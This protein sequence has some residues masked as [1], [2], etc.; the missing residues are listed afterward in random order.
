MAFISR[1]APFL[2]LFSLLSCMAVTVACVTTPANSCQRNCCINESAAAIG[3]ALTDAEVDPYLQES[4]SIAEVN[5]NATT[6]ISLNGSEMTIKTHDVMID[7]PGSLVHVHVDVQNCTVVGIWSQYK[8]FIPGPLPNDSGVG[9]G[10][11]P[12]AM[13]K[14]V[15]SSIAGVD[16]EIRAILDSASE[17]ETMPSSQDPQTEMQLLDTY[18]SPAQ[19]SIIAMKEKHYSDDQITA[20]L[21]EYGYGWDPKTGACWKGNAPTEEE[22]KTIDKIR[23]PEYSPFTVL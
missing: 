18:V 11:T 16:S 23:G 4:Y 22:Q 15:N 13:A 17:F 14:Q 12:V 19:K 8:R 10:M 20:L 21:N 1:I 6:T 7:T 9:T 2:L 3:I 5:S